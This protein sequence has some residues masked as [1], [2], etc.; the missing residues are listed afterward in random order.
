MHPRTGQVAF[1]KDGQP[2]FVAGPHDNA[3]AI[4]RPLLRF[5]GEGHFHYVMPLGGGL[6]D[7]AEF[8]LDEDEVEGE[9]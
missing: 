8:E 3:D 7:L 9:A 4:M 2:F 5:A 6:E 1:G